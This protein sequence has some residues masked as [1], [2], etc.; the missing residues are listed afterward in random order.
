MPFQYLNVFIFSVE[1]N[2]ADKCHNNF[3]DDSGNNS[4]NNSEKE[5]LIQK[6]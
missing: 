4:E 5:E 2:V 3:E 1:M 6:T